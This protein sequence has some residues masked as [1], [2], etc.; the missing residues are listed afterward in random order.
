MQNTRQ[1]QTE[2]TLNSNQHEDEI[3]LF[4]LWN[5]LLED[6]KQIIAT[7]LGIII[8]AGVYAFSITPTFQSKAYLLPPTLDTIQEINKLDILLEND[9]SYL[10]EDIFKQFLQDLTSRSLKTELFNEHNLIALYNKNY[11][12]LTGE[13]QVR[14]YNEAFNQ[15]VKDLSVIIPK[16]TTELSASIDLSLQSSADNLPILLNAYLKKVVQ[17]TTQNLIA[18]INYKQAISMEQLNLKISSAR[19]ISEF[20]R[21][22][23]IAMLEE[24]IQI[25]RSLGIAELKEIGANINVELAGAGSFKLYYLG[26]K[27]LEAEKATL[28][29]RKSND[30]FIAN[31]RGSQEKYDLLANFKINKDNISVSNIDQAPSFGEKIKPSK[32]LILAVAGVLGLMLGIF[33]ALIRRAIKN[34]AAEST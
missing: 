8:L 3:D 10:Q 20:K 15:F 5:N 28:E 33:I 23:R 29:K 31:L 22:D 30:P 14:E 26:Y 19:K 11:H 7:T 2:Q 25:A 6:K 27:T 32:A 24:A 4:E 12:E 16:K 34:R 18:D 13:K 17:Q 1:N 9:P 21:L